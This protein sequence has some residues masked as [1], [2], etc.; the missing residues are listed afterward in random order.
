MSRREKEIG[1]KRE[2]RIARELERQ[3]DVRMA[4]AAKE[5]MEGV[6]RAMDRLP[7]R[8]SDLLRS[9][10]GHAGLS[11][12]ARRGFVFTETEL[13]SLV[14]A[15]RQL[16]AS[17]ERIGPGHVDSQT[18]N[19]CAYLIDLA[20][21][22]DDL[23]DGYAPDKAETE[24]RELNL[25][26]IEQL[27]L[28][29]DAPPAAPDV[30]VDVDP[31]SIL[32]GIDVPRKKLARWLTAS[33]DG[34]AQLK[35][36][37]VVGPAGMGKTTL[38]MDVFRQIEGQFQC[39]AVARLS[40]RPPHTDKLLRHIMSQI[41]GYLIVIDDMW[42]TLDWELIWDAFPS[43]R[44]HSRI[45][46]TTRI[47]S[48]ARSCCSHPWP[49]GLVHEVK[50]LGATD[51]ERLFSA[52]A[53]G[54]P[55]PAS[56]G[57]VSNEILRV[58]DGTPLL[59]IAMAGLVSKQM[60]EEDYD[61]E[62]GESR[63]TMDISRP[64]VAAYLASGI[65]EVKQVEDTLSP[66]YDNLPCELRLLSLY[67]STFPQGH[68]IDKHL[69]IRKWKA[70]GL[71]AVHTLQSGFEERAEECFSQL[72]QRYIIRPARTR[73]R[74]CDCECNPCSYQVNHF[75][76]QLL[77]SKSADKNFV[78]TSCCDTGTLRGSSGLQI[79]RVFLHHGQQQQQPADQEVPAQ[80]EEM[81]SCTRSLTVSGEVDGISL[82]MFPHLVVL[83]LQGWEKLKDDDLPRIFSSGKLFLLRYLSLRNTRVSELPPEIGMLS[84][85][86]TL[87]ASHTRIAQLPPEVCTLRSLE[88]L[89]LRSTRIQQLPERIDD[90]VALRHLRAGDGAASTRI[91]KGI[92]WGMLRDTLETLAAVD[93]RECSADVVRKLSLLRCLE[94]LSVSLSLRQCTDKEYQDNLSFLVQRLKCLRSLTIRCEL[95]CSME[96]LDFSPEDAPQNLRHVAM[97]ARFLTVP[98]W[99]AGLNHLSSLHI[100]VCKLAPEGVKILGRLHRLECLELGLDFLP[101]EA[102]VIQGQGFMSSSQNRSNRAPLNSK[103]HEEEDDDDEKNGIIIYPFRELLR[104]SVDCRVPWLVFKEGAM[105][106]LTDLELKLSTGPASHESVPS[107]IANL[108]SLEQVAV[109][110]DAWYINSRS[111]RATVDA[112]RRQVAEL[113]YTVKLVNNGVEEDVE[114]LINPRRGS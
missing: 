58:C 74:A 4:A 86:E 64:C 104:L 95:G 5:E 65:R 6:L 109:Q 99:I 35:V 37:S 32:V 46:I 24:L 25:A 102:I 38:A 13:S 52:V 23:I 97:H 7:G 103:I 110:Y 76:F 40:A 101:R 19:H 51:S 80:M 111:V 72:V 94:V 49:N 106:K 91:P 41:T 69:L 60:Q 17:A 34:E 89:D 82:E 84:S 22:I 27:L 100:R 93:L 42:R 73:R 56:S 71:I 88:E 105:P 75:M 45:I 96:F 18:V 62:E 12:L 90:L 55:R 1:R 33:D 39:R 48:V 57:R 36:L 68:V 26:W 50:P 47:R 85:L 43:N 2:V 79:R 63:V 114:A 107:G 77:A 54:W 10:R 29:T 98:R 92:D 81:F 16:L 66:S 67:M 31:P 61:D 11:V 83:D 28:V 113:R 112:I 44:C 15:L 53:H 30:V 14:A 8:I 20:R 70:E 108:L 87:D 9:E 78:T 59:I 3:R 21:W